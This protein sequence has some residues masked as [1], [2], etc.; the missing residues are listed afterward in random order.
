MIAAAGGVGFGSSAA[1]GFVADGD[2][3]GKEK[4][5]TDGGSSVGFGSS[6]TFG[7]VVD[8]DGG[9]FGGGFGMGRTLGVLGAPDLAAPPAIVG[10]I[11]ESSAATA[12]ADWSRVVVGMT[13]RR[14]GPAWPSVSLDDTVESEVS[15][16]ESE[17]SVLESGVSV[18][19]S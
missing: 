7:I 6:A 15:V 5:E 11:G 17:V 2:E 12:D 16:L 14:H 1:F 8:G 13:A 18:L 19:G 10:D 3:D 9:V 4:R